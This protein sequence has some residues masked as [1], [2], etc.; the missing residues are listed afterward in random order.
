MATSHLYKLAVKI[1]GSLTSVGSLIDP[2]TR[3]ELIPSAVGLGSVGSVEVVG[4][5]EEGGRARTNSLPQLTAA[6]ESTRGGSSFSH[7]ST[8]YEHCQQGKKGNRLLGVD[9]GY[10]EA[11]DEDWS[12]IEV[13]DVADMISCGAM[14]TN[15]STLGEISGNPTG[16]ALPREEVT[17]AGTWLVDTNQTIR[18]Y[19]QLQA[20][21]NVPGDYQMEEGVVAICYERICDTTGTGEV[22]RG[23]EGPGDVGRKCGFASASDVENTWISTTLEILANRLA[24]D[25]RTGT[26][27]NYVYRVEKIN[28][29]QLQLL[30]RNELSSI[31]A[32]MADVEIRDS[33]TFSDDNHIRKAALKWVKLT[34]G[35]VVA[36]QCVVMALEYAAEVTLPQLAAAAIMPSLAGFVLVAGVVCAIY[37]AADLGYN[38]HK[39]R[40]AH[41]TGYFE[42]RQT[43]GQGEEVVELMWRD[44]LIT[45]DTQR[46]EDTQC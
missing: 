21:T 42:I 23:R 27:S 13:V 20:E 12:H 5:G 24:A 30:L 35:A 34:A 45:E 15:Q 31:A 39:M 8:F 9:G 26:Q 38:I 10:R 2:S 16:G 41:A 43:E 14:R 17:A 11:G 7:L 6:A 36:R 29:G 46:T 40:N 44:E 4:N 37:V 33:S 1:R 18:P 19:K 28:V 32:E 22:A 3:T 25:L